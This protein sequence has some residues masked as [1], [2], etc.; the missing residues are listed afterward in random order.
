MDSEQSG[1]VLDVS[2][3]PQQEESVMEK[4]VVLKL[5]APEKS[6]E[7]EKPPAA[8]EDE[9]D[10]EQLPVNGL[11][12]TDTEEL[13]VTETVAV[14]EEKTQEE[15]QDEESEEESDPAA[16]A[17]PNEDESSEKI[18]D[19]VAALDTEPEN[20]EEQLEP[21]NDQE[22]LED[23]TPEVEPEKV[24]ES[25]SEAEI[26]VQTT[27]EPAALQQ[28]VDIEPPSPEKASEQEEEEAT[29][30]S[31][32]GEVVKE[33]VE[34]RDVTKEV[35]EE[36]TAVEEMLVQT[37]EASPEKKEAEKLV[38]VVE[39]SPEKKEAEKLVETVEA[40]PEK[41]EVEKLVET[42]SAADVLLETKKEAETV[43]EPEKTPAAENVTPL[44]EKMEEKPLAV[45]TLKG[46]EAA[47][48]EAVKPELQNEE[49]PVPAAGTLSFALLEQEQTK[50]ALRTS[51]TLVVLR[52]L[53]GSGKSFLA[54]AISDAY[55]DNCALFCADDHAVKPESPETSADGY[56][57]LDE[58]VV[59]CCSAGTASSVLVIVDDTNHTQER[60]ATLGEIAEQ[61]NLV[62][63]F[64]EPRT[65][66]SR[67][68]AQLVKRSRRGLQEAQLEAMKGSFTE[69]S[70]PLYFGWFLLSSIQDK[71][72]CTSMDFLKTLDT[73]E[74]FK[75]HL[76]DCE[77]VKKD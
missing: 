52:G 20:T 22:P 75:K 13:I 36:K 41:A 61:H 67:D 54:R 19:P 74:A 60:L 17:P 9:E 69:V 68:P 71:V 29:M 46:A 48:E 3:P 14:L 70:I 65:E 44:E 5:E 49:E 31:E 42:V 28:L 55:K 35:E 76:I 77:Y 11:N 56:K 10:D 39:A 18:F 7:P 59:A 33:R 37:V 63:V 24:L 73:M 34:E 57:A 8:D 47:A 32:A 58:A 23:I 15:I 72:R 6:E 21:E 51:R 25:V 27:S 43:P 45:D 2:D 4:E 40:S 53:P 64:L 12:S 1:E 26:N 30:D 38:E 62:A 50:T 66:W 16:A